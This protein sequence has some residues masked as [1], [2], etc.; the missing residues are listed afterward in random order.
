MW[1]IHT[2]V[3]KA[4]TPK[5]PAHLRKTLL[6]VMRNGISPI[7]AMWIFR[8]K[9]HDRKVRIWR[10][11]FFYGLFSQFWGTDEIFSKQNENASSRTH[12]KKLKFTFCLLFWTFNFSFHSGL[13]VLHSQRWIFTYVLKFLWICTYVSETLRISLKNSCLK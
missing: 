5:E 3:L 7:L 9:R 13:D 1:K 4:H 10:T 6:R 2:N 8:R 11:A 12:Q